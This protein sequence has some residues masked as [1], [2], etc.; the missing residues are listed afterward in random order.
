MRVSGAGWTPDSPLQDCHARPFA[1]K[2]CGYGPAHQNSPSPASLLAV[3]FP[4]RPSFLVLFVVLQPAFG[5]TQS[6]GFGAF[7]AAST[8]AFGAAASTPSFGGFGAS[9]T[10]AFGAASS[11]PAFGTPGSAAGSPFGTPGSAFGAT[12]ASGGFGTPPAAAP[13]AAVSRPAHLSQSAR[14]LARI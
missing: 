2:L 8:P 13:A 10:P 12:P 4:A 7:G 11:T 9:S 14:P 5:Q 6:T 1:P 3:A